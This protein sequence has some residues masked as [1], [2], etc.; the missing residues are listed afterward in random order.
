MKYNVQF[1]SKEEMERYMGGGGKKGCG[2]G[3][4]ALLLVLLIVGKCCG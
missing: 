2:C 4:W 1:D 3:F